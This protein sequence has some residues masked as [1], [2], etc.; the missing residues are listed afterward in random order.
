[1]RQFGTGLLRLALCLGLFVT[2][3]IWL[4]YLIGSDDDSGF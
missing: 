2:F 4:I 1:M 3:P